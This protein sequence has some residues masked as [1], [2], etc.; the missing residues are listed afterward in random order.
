MHISSLGYRCELD[1]RRMPQNFTNK[2]SI[3]VQVMAWYRQDPLC[4]NLIGG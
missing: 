4:H 2:K 3:L 1:I